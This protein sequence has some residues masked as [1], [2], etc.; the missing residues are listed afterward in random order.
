VQQAAVD[1]PQRRFH[2][3]PHTSQGLLAR[4]SRCRQGVGIAANTERNTRCAMGGST[5]T[6]QREVTFVQQIKK[7]GNV[8][9]HELMGP[10]V[11]DHLRCFAMF[12]V[13]S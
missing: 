12:D 2:Y 13:A 1:A 5:R 9:W 4:A 11:N 8:F 7:S 10:S 6:P 3:G